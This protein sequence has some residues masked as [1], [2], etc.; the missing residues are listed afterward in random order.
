MEK[1][2]RRQVT[3]GP[4]VLT[5]RPEVTSW[6]QPIRVPSLARWNGIPHGI[7]SPFTDFRMTLSELT[8]PTFCRVRGFIHDGPRPH[9]GNC[10]CGVLFLSSG[11]EER[12][13]F[14]TTFSVIF[15]LAIWQF[16]T[17]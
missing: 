17:D 1:A 9:T 7:N 14:V 10:L 8:P 16:L 13:F 15:A 6:N 3:E 12:F 11:A 5:H 4:L 2:I